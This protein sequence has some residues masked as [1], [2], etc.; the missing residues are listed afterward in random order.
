MEDWQSDKCE[1]SFLEGV[2]PVYLQTK[3]D[4]AD[5]WLE[6]SYKGG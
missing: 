1:V 3:L 5:F 2:P 6:H 4:E